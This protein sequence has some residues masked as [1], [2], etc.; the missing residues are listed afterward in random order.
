MTLIFR[1]CYHTTMVLLIFENIFCLQE[2]KTLFHVLLFY[3]KLLII[4]MTF[5][6]ANTSLD[7][8][9]PVYS[10]YVSDGMWD[11]QDVG[12]LRCVMFLM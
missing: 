10:C 5:R 7:N 8:V 12:C 4:C 1:T 6:L 9:I 11:I 3:L 2:K